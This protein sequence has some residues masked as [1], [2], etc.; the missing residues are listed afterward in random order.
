MFPGA[1]PFL[2]GF[3]ST[4]IYMY[5][6][7]GCQQTNAISD[8]QHLHNVESS[9][10][11][12]SLCSFRVVDIPLNRGASSELMAADRQSKRECNQWRQRQWLL[13]S[14][15]IQSRKV[16]ENKYIPHS[17]VAAMLFSLYWVCSVTWKAMM[18]ASSM[19]MKDILITKLAMSMHSC[20]ACVMPR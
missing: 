20:K 9:R 15:L 3:S 16:R 7:E 12:P 19:T 8:D 4:D 13:S 6:F 2:S 17:R 18:R 11:K 1:I 10:A 5:I 14:K